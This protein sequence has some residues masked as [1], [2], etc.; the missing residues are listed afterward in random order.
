MVTPKVRTSILHSI[1]RYCI[2]LVRVLLVCRDTVTI[3]TL[4][5]KNIN[6]VWLTVS[7]V[8]SIIVMVG[9]MVA[10]RQIWC[11]RRS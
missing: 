11:W 8:S 4:I 7:E 3:A 2:V 1:G 9:N 5:K 10:C 6:W